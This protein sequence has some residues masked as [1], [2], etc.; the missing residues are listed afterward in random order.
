MS[1]A[2]LTE[3]GKKETRK[4]DTCRVPQLS[5]LVYRLIWNI[6]PRKHHGAKLPLRLHG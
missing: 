2:K 1:S 5:K 3:E 6:T 4:E